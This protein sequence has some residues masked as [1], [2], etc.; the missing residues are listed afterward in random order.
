MPSADVLDFE[1]LLAPIPGEKPTGVDLRV[2]AGPSSPYYQVKDGRSAAR[3]AERRIEGGQDESPPDWKPVVT[4]A[5]KALGESTKDLELVAYLI[6]GLC[7]TQGVAG[8]RDGFKLARGLAENF[9]DGLLPAPDEDGLATTLGPLAGLNG[10]DAEGT[11]IAPINRIAIT[12]SASFG[13]LTT[14]VY[15]QAVAVAKI[16]DPEARERRIA[17][18]SP[19]MEMV[20]KAVD[21]T[22]APFYRT[23][24]EDLTAALEEFAKLNAVLDEK[25]GRFAPPSS[26]IRNGLEGVL[27]AIN[28]VAR[29]KLAVTATA[30]APTSDAPSGTDA[31]GQPNTGT[32]G[33]SGAGG[34][35]LPTVRTRDDALNAILQ[36]S[37]YFRRTEPH[38]MVPYALEQAVRWARMPLP[39]LMTELID[40]DSARRALFKQV[41]IRNDS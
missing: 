12:D 23:L 39:E 30:A 15:L 20:Q 8:I 6:E 22:P 14:A 16:V 3:A 28:D 37:D 36:L 25:G 31:G 10:D 17:A 13:K 26:A 38:S 40:D 19:S 5:T 9:W 32:G 1:K 27:A 7:R 41:G 11:L 34:E 18:G 4:A 24:V 21:E 35:R 2:N 29:G 33:D